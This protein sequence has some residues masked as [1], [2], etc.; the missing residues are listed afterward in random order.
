M[1]RKIFDI[2]RNHSEDM[3]IRNFFSHQNP[4]GE[5]PTDRAI[6]SGFVCRKDYGTYYREGLAENI[7]KASLYQ[8]VAYSNGV[9]NYY[10]KKQAEIAISVVKGWMSSPGHRKNILTQTYD[11]EGIDVAVTLERCEVYITQNFC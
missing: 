11:A 6:R 8:Y 5:S 1:D 10:W 3:S 2:A 9:P 4:D 7:F